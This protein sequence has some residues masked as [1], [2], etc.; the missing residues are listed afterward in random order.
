MVCEAA[1]ERNKLLDKIEW[2]VAA[3]KSYDS[4]VGP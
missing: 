1:Y 2:L 3:I 4:K